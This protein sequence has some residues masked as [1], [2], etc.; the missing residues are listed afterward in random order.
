MRKESEKEYIYIHICIYVCITELLCCIPE[1]YTI[2]E[3]NYILQL[4]KYFLKREI[5]NSN[6]EGL[7][8]I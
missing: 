3:I 2:L 7:W 5:N 6:V 1:T 4:K 8:K